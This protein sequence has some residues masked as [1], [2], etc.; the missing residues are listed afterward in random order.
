MKQIRFNTQNMREKKTCSTQIKKYGPISAG[1]HRKSLEY[2]STIL[3]G[4]SSDFSSDFQPTS[5][6]FPVGNGRKSLEKS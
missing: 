1:K 6:S 5:N 4:M 2:G 3:G